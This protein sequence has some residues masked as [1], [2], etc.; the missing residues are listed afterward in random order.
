M[1]EGMKE[2]KGFTDRDVQIWLTKGIAVRLLGRKW[3]FL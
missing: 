3:G 2:F 1:E